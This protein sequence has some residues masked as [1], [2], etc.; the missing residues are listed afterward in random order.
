MRVQGTVVVISTMVLALTACGGGGGGSNG[1]GNNP[2]PPPPPPP[3]TYTVGGTVSGLIGTVVLQN[4]A[5][6]NL[7]I[8]ANGAFT[9]STAAAGGAAYAATVLTQPA[10]QT[11]TASSA[12]GT[13][14]ASNV[15][16]ISVTCVTNPLAF[17][18]S[19]PQSGSTDHPRSMVPTLTFDRALDVNTVASAIS[20]ASVV[21]EEPMTATAADAV[22]TITP[23]RPLLP[24]SLYTITASTEVR[25]ANGE[26]PAAAVEATFMTRDGLWQP[27]AA[28][29]AA[30]LPTGSRDDAARIVSDANGIATAVWPQFNGIRRNMMASRYQTATGW[31]EPEL[32]EAENLGD[33]LSPE[34]AVDSAGNVTAVWR[35]N[36]GTR[37]NAWSNR[38]TVNGALGSWGTPTLIES[39]TGTISEVGVAANAGGAVTAVFGQTDG[40]RVNLWATRYSGGAWGAPEMIET[41]NT[42]G[43]TDIDV[44]ADAQ[45]NVIAVWRQSD[46]TRNNIWSNSAS[47]GVWG[48]AELRETSDAGTAY[49]PQIAMDAAGTAAV[50]WAQENG[51]NREMIA[52]RYLPGSGWSGT[53]VLD[54]SGVGISA[55]AVDFD[56]RGRAFATWVC[57]HG[58]MRVCISTFGM[59]GN[60]WSPVQSSN[61][62]TASTNGGFRMTVDRG[63]HVMTTWM[64]QDSSIVVSPGGSVTTTYTA[65][66]TAMRYLL[67]YGGW[68]EAEFLD[69]LETYSNTPLMM[70]LRLQ[71]V[72]EASGSVL[73]MWPDETRNLITKRFE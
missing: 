60:A 1:G 56:G 34:L 6:N 22:V 3:V 13:I 8:S 11:C 50:I 9:F 46:G 29:R 36:D 47:S 15:T 16:N 69:D 64:T 12:S 52:N 30:P 38:Y 45:S 63:G 5:A 59:G 40:V 66:P 23:A 7:S 21:G 44:A 19:N 42:S 53:R 70:D 25:G 73:V 43:V 18:T 48:T 41:N 27:S 72:V 28:L 24:V 54:T 31:S 49:A 68:G 20:F 39:T 32:I 61:V 2:P 26:I 57:D 55:M 51:A 62:N 14:A 71:S 58:G 67:G 4:N 35:Q 17:V 10:G 37:Y 33:A 65:R